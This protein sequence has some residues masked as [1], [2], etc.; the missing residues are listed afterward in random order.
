[1][2]IFNSQQISLTNKAKKFVSPPMSYYGK[3]QNQPHQDSVEFQP[4]KMKGGAS[5]QSGQIQN[6]KYVDYINRIQ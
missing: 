1:M 3:F 5:I 4:M 6:P 2:H